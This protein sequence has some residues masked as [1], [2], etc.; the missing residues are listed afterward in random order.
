MFEV[1]EEPVSGHGMGHVI[2]I[3]Q[4]NQNI[5]VEQRSHS[6]D[7]LFTQ[8]IDLLIGDQPTTTFKRLEA[9]HSSTTRLS[10]S[11]RECSTGQLRQ[12]STGRPVRLSSKA[13]CCL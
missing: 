6:V 7:I 13:L 11:T 3:E 4:R 1:G 2:S 10:R 12:H 5:D 8:P 9:P